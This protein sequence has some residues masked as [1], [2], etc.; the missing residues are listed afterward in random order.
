MNDMR[1]F[2]AILLF[3]FTLLV[4]A[5]VEAEVIFT[6]GFE[7]SDPGNGNGAPTIESFIADPGGLPFGGGAAQL[8]WSVDDADT[9]TIEPDLGVVTSTSAEVTVVATTP[10][11]LTAMNEA[12]TAVASTSVLVAGDAPPPI[13]YSTESSEDLIDAALDRGELDELTALVYKV[14]ALFG[15]DRLPAEYAAD[16]DMH[17]TPIM[18]E[19]AYRYDELSAQAQEW[20]RPFMLP[21]DDPNS[22]Y[23]ATSG[24]LHMQQEA[25]QWDSLTVD[26][27]Q[28]DVFINWKEGYLGA[29]TD[30]FMEF[31]VAPAVERSWRLL[32]QL[33]GGHPLST[34]DDPQNPDDAYHI[35]FFR[36]AENKDLGLTSFGEFDFELMRWPTHLMVNL[37]SLGDVPDSESF[38]SVQYLAA[39]IAH[40]LMHAVQEAFAKKGRGSNPADWLDESNATWAEHYVYPEFD[41]E[42]EY[43]DDFMDHSVWQLDDVS[44]LHEYGGYLFHLFIHDVAGADKVADVYRQGA[45]QADNFEGVDAALSGLGGLEETWKR[46]VVANWNVDPFDRYWAF[47]GVAD[48]V[49]LAPGFEVETIVL[50]ST[51][52]DDKAV[53]MGFGG[54]DS[55]EQINYMNSLSAQYFHFDLEGDVRSLLFANGHTYELLEGTPDGLPLADITYYAKPMT[56]DERRG[57]AVQALVKRNG[58]WLSNAYDLT[59]VAFVPFC[60]DVGSESI[61]E[62]VLIFSNSR[63][64]IGDRDAIVPKGLNPMMFA[65]DMSCG[66]WTG[67]ASLGVDTTEETI[68]MTI[69]DLLF[70]RDPTP[71]DVLMSGAG[72]WPWFDGTIIPRDTIYAVLFSSALSLADAQVEWDYSLHSADCSASGQGMLGAGDAQ[73]PTVLDIRP[74][75]TGPTDAQQSIYRSFYVSL[76]FTDPSPTAITGTCNGSPYQGPFSNGVVGGF[77]NSSFGELLIDNTGRSITASWTMEDQGI[78]YTLNLDAVLG[79]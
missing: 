57:F 36:S 78:T 52:E 1:G 7:D 31:V 4:Y 43:A 39:T 24:A 19:L 29:A 11:T 50:D 3:V 25:A 5:G 58:A 32:T 9:I 53:E 33:M 41:T 61:E 72:E 16:G 17:G 21:P 77:R 79:F 66:D 6:H 44:G 27:P 26:T 18:K 14:F 59:D 8:N 12:G 55:S 74:S 22:W 2:I 73:S 75:L 64:R 38:N 60:Q 48:G 70:T 71:F 54:A 42:Q 28:G 23:A 62:I 69:S 34:F 40:E 65:S 63:F 47:D 56:S 51:M 68:N 35:Y 45:T 20:M 76:I 13:D 15:D 46:F 30:D 37:E 49:P 67:S 10:Y